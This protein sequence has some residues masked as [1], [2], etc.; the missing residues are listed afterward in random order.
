MNM[1]IQVGALLVISSVLSSCRESSTVEQPPASEPGNFW[2]STNLPYGR[3]IQAILATGADVLVGTSDSTFF[4]SSDRGDTWTHGDL[5]IGFEEDL[6]CLVRLNPTYLFAGTGGGGLYRSTDNSL[7]WTRIQLPGPGT[8][9]WNLSVGSSMELLAAVFY[10]GVYQSTDS[11]STWSRLWQGL[12]D[13][14]QS[15][16][17]TP[18]GF[19]LAGT[20]SGLF[21]SSDNGATWQH[22]TNTVPSAYIHSIVLS[23]NDYIFIACGNTVY[24]STDLGLTWTNTGP[25]ATAEVFCLAVSPYEHVLA[26]TLGAGVF[27]SSDY[28]DTWT[29]EITGL[30]NSTVRAI[31]VSSDGFA[32]A[33]TDTSGIF[34]STKPLS[35]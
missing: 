14:V 28:G 12:D 29:Q 30:S 4:R 10:G 34:R 32:Y 9:V 13:R 22:D 5:G 26:G 8:V 15:V 16:A 7:T 11:G 20:N 2:Q 23:S 19:L 21:T 25:E 1:K 27:I 35:P 6:L 18:L 33:G 3:P 31:A 17:R 24:R